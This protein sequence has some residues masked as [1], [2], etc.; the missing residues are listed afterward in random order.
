MDDDINVTINSLC[1]YT[2]NLIASVKSQLIFNEAS[3]NKYK[4]SF[5]ERY[6]ERRELSD[7]FFKLYIGSAQQVND[8]KNLICA[9]QTKD[10]TNAPNKKS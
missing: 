5:N 10:R 4:K 1:L 6:T 9:H 7:M 3:Q 8:P 2:A